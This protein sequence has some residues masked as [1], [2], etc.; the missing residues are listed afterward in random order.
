MKKIIVVFAALIS[1]SALS[2]AF[3]AP[4]ISAE[5]AVLIHA[6]SGRVLY[7]KDAGTPRLIASTT[8][9]MTA[10]VVL[11]NCEIDERFEIP[12]ECT[13]IEGSSMYLKAGESYSVRDLLYGMLLCSGNDAASALALHCA[14]SIESFAG[15]MN[16]KARGLGLQNTSFENPHGLDGE[17][18]YAS[19]YDL[20]LITAEAMR[21]SEF[22]E[23]V[24][25]KSYSLG[26]K[27]YV[28]HN[29][30][31]W[32]VDGC[33]GV[34]TGYTMAAGRTLVSCVERAGMK[35]IFVTLSA[36]GDWE[37]H[38]AIYEWAYNEYEYAAVMPMGE[39]CRV[40]VI[41]GESESVGIVGDLQ[42]KL[43][44][45]R[46]IELDFAVEL[47]RFVYAGINKGEVAGSLIIRETDGEEVTFPLYYSESVP[48]AE[49]S[50][51]SPVQR[52]FKAWF[53]SNK[54]GF[55]PGMG[56]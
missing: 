15:L 11:D 38:T 22:A 13:G 46:G 39:L 21:N 31:L 7:A 25:S 43:L 24:S 30:L 28:N 54:Y 14:G 12:L 49:E 27:T 52:F 17:N 2:V 26:D 29:K 51:L 9:I 4:E 16:E 23:I 42:L 47:P 1:L 20:A 53:L 41:S 34:K 44:F 45:R 8:K 48:I 55:V 35:L 33:V 19:A 3:S 56:K 10:L 50:R 37:D 32:R 18:Q 36:P 40:P 6:D 5:A